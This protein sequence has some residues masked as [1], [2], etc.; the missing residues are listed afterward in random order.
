MKRYINGEIGIEEAITLYR[1][2]KKLLSKIAENETQHKGIRVIGTELG[3]RSVISKLIKKL[4]EDGLVEIRIVNCRGGKKKVS[5]LTEKGKNML[6]MEEP[7]SFLMEYYK[8][9]Y[10]KKTGLEYIQSKKDLNY[11]KKLYDAVLIQNCF[12]NMVPLDVSKKCIEIFFSNNYYKNAKYSISMLASKINEL[13]LECKNVIGIQV[14]IIRNLDK[15]KVSYILIIKG[16]IVKISIDYNM[17]S[18]EALLKIEKFKEI[19][20]YFR[21]NYEMTLDEYY[22]LIE[23]CKERDISLDKIKFKEE[24]LKIMGIPKRFIKQ[25][26]INVLIEE[27][28]STQKILKSPE[29]LK[30]LK[31][32]KKCL[33]LSGEP[34]LGKTL[35]ASYLAYYYAGGNINKA[36]K[37][38]F[39]SY[40]EFNNDGFNI[41]G[42]ISNKELII[43]DD[44]HLMREY[45]INDLI[46]AIYDNDT[47][48]IFTTNLDEY[49]ILNKLQSIDNMGGLSRRFRERFEVIYI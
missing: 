40:D 8:T 45:R 11:I 31:S 41:R 18:L 5:Y 49:Q 20:D 46:R 16:R 19:S 4:V 13:I 33:V 7:L 39:Y 6:K 48:A 26:L 1:P 47:L 23:S 21:K 34:G 3:I 27:Y 37:V 15:R 2:I 17:E 43:V 36:K 24:I 42:E 9:L 22:L 28:P 35:L 14:D 44:F 25:I 29:I 32:N 38:R 10:R 30:E 12:K